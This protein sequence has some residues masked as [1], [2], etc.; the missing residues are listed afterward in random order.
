[1]TGYTNTVNAWAVDR[2]SGG[3]LRPPVGWAAIAGGGTL[4]GIGF[5]V[6]LLIANL[7]FTERSL[8]EAK[9]G[10]LAA[11]VASSLHSSP[12]YCFTAQLPARPATAPYRC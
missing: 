7:A 12:V 11:V 10:I 9:V 4:A 6:S 1:M 3:R 8:Q 5:K 2:V